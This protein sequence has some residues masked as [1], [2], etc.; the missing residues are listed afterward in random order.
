MA[1]P[2]EP[3]DRAR[4]P[5]AWKT[6][7]TEQNVQALTWLCEAFAEVRERVADPT[8]DF[9]GDEYTHEIMH[10]LEEMVAATRSFWCR[11][12]ELTA[13]VATREAMIEKVAAEAVKGIDEEFQAMVGSN[14]LPTTIIDAV[15]GPGASEA[16]VEAE[17]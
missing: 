8:Y 5:E 9:D 12:L 13:L 6:W 1:N 3:M 7:R 17:G 10:K 11:E 15:E 4:D 2:T 14:P 16:E